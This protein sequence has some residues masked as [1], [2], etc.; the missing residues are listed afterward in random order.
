MELEKAV[1]KLIETQDSYLKDELDI[2]IETV[3]KELKKL[4]EKDNYY[5]DIQ[6]AYNNVVKESENSINKNKI[7]ERIEWLK[8]NILNNDYASDNDKD[9]AEYQVNILQELLGDDK[10]AS[11]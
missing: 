11:R 6:K 9:I 4:Q 8:E 10:N 5:E 7:K 2:A 3:L 1:N